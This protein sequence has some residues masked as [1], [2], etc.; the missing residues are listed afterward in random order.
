MQLACTDKVRP[1]TLVS[2][3]VCL[4][5]VAG[6]LFSNVDVVGCVLVHNPVVFR[7]IAYET[8]FTLDDKDRLTSASGPGYSDTFTYTGLGLRL[9]KNDSTG[10]YAYL[11]DGVSPASSVLSDGRL[12]FTPGISQ[13]VGTP[14]GAGARSM[15]RTA[16]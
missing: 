11:C 12:S 10:G 5:G 1:I 15:L 2:A 7:H 4:G 16:G 8:R 13:I 6:F 9:T 3:A 14:N